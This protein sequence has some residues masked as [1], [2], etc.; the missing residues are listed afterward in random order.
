MIA[1]P[2]GP[3]FKKLVNMSPRAIRAWGRDRRARCASFESTRR[4]LPRLADLKAKPL[5]K[6]TAADCA[7]AARVVS[8]NSRMDGMRREHGCTTPINVAL[9]NWGRVGPGCGEPPADCKPK[10][11]S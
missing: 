3:T 9:R 5:A 4:R 6:W 7:F 10:R 11:K 8:F 1:C 2:A